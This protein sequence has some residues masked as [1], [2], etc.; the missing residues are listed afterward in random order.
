MNR[1]AARGKAFLRGQPALV[2]RDQRQHCRACTARPGRFTLALQAHWARA[3][4]VV[5]Q[6]Q[7]GLRQ[8]RQ[9]VG[10]RRVEID[11]DDPVGH[12]PHIVDRRQVQPQRRARK[13]RQRLAQR[14]RGALGADRR[15]IGPGPVAQAE[16]V[17]LPVV[18][19]DPAIGQRGHHAAFGIEAHQPLDRRGAQHLRG[20]G[21]PRARCAEGI[22]V[23]DQRHRQ[24]PMLG[25]PATR[26]QQ[27]QRQQKCQ[28]GA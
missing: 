13:R 9:Q 23:A 24:R 27:D 18:G 16:D 17:A 15:S 5:G 19:H 28:S 21:K 14:R 12:H 1:P 10:H 2:R 7:F 20:R 8:Q 26:P 25:A 22:G 3:A 11:L 4:L 6:T